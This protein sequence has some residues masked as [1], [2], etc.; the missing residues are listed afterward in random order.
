VKT[1]ARIPG[2]FCLTL[3]IAD[4]RLRPFAVVPGSAPWPE[5]SQAVRD[6]FDLETSRH[7][8]TA[9]GVGVAHE[10][11]T[12]RNGLDLDNHAVV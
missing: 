5:G 8:Q 10:R 9:T 4:G 1:S 12:P 2:F 6:I 11:T 7:L 3:E